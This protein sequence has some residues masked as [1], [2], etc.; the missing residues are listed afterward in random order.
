MVA[1]PS[2]V[3]IIA[4]SEANPDF[5]TCDLLAQSE[6]FGGIAY[7]ITNSKKLAGISSG[8]LAMAVDVS[9]WLFSRS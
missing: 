7:L 6:H 2:E 5:V 4:D 8:W 3:A 1:G 9:I